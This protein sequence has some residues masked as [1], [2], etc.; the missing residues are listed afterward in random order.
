MEI[1]NC[2]KM[3]GVCQHLMPATVE[4]ISQSVITDCLS[5]V[6]NYSGGPEKRKVNF[7]I[8]SFKKLDY[9]S[10]IN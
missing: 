2:K 6:S 10:F 3:K 9:L 4:E 7:F 1:E 8:T 5:L